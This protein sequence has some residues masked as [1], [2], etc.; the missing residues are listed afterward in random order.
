MPR[1][2]V[3]ITG[4]G[5][6]APN[7]C[8]KEAFWQACL[9]GRSGVRPITR[10]AA[11][12]FS[13]RIAGQIPDFSP[14]AFGLTPIEC[15]FLD[16]GTQ[17]AVAAANLALDD[18]G[19]RGAE[20]EHVPRESIGVYIGTAM[21]SVQ[22]GERLWG[23][24]TGD[25]AHAPRI[26][27]EGIDPSAFILSCMPSAVI[28]SHH[29]LRGPC[30]TI[31][32]GCS[33]GADAIGQAFWQIQEGTAER[34]LAGGSDSPLSPGGL[35]VFSAMHA[36]STHNDEPERASRP[37]EARRD[38]FVLSEG[39]AV[40]LLEERALALARG[41]Y[42]Y[43]EIRTYVTNNNAYHMAT[44]PKDG[45]PLQALLQQ[46]LE[47]SHLSP[48]QLGYIN[49]HGSS[50]VSNDLAETIA[51][52]TFFGARAYQ[53]PISSTKS[54]IGHTQGAASAIE[55]LVTV[56]ALDRQLL[57]P[58]IN[59]EVPDPCCDLDYVPNVARAADA[60]QPLRFALS[61]SSGFGGINTAL[62]LA[63]N[64]A[65][66]E[67]S[68]ASP[69]GQTANPAARL[70][71]R[72]VITGVGVVAPNGIGKAAFWT[73]VCAGRS[74]MGP[75]V[76]HYDMERPLQCVGEIKNFRAEDYIDRKLVKRTDRMSHFALIAA[77]EALLD[78][79]L[80]LERENSLRI[81][82]VIANTLAGVE[83]V[84][85]QMKRLYQLGPNFMSA[86]TALAWL[87][88]AN[89]GRVSVHYGLK[90]YCKVPINDT[91]GGLDAL[92]QGYQAIRRDAAD[93]LIAGG[94]EAPLSP[95]VLCML[96]AT[97]AF[98]RKGDPPCY[99]PFDLRADGL[100]IAEGAGICILEEY[101]HAIRRGAHIYAEIV[102]YAQTCAPGDLTPYSIPDSAAY[103]RA[104]ELALA[105]A[106]MP[107]N[108]IACVFPDGRAIPAWD[109]IET[110]ALSEFFGS[111]FDSL[112][113][114]VPRTQF[115]HTLS[116]AGAIDT[117]CALLTLKEH[118]VPPTINCET[119]NPHHYPPG[120]VRERNAAL[121]F[122][123]QGG[124]VCARGLG[125]SHAV[126][127]LKSMW[128]STRQDLPS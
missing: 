64:D 105:Q 42:V 23:K 65:L 86:H 95:F 126:L 93:I 107:T 80:E 32:T 11:G 116:A 21:A 120:L 29:G 91:C 72:V 48:E 75:P 38:G 28:A 3:V 18:A 41:A 110:A 63:R 4:L 117:I 35:T 54:L 37:Y 122:S 24:A 34:M 82:A 40:L 109:A 98:H 50:T 59:L 102:G 124:L 60:N 123:S 127:A 12:N 43:A 8:G 56:L 76:R 9:Q 55:A 47:S 33:A 119:P 79:G 104:L 5:V 106:E 45:A 101:E 27:P 94:T 87:H 121:R 90:G 17:L 6:L 53:I 113:C 71:R 83:Y 89:V 61:H 70:R 20:L 97:P 46:A 14:A 36:L 99:R 85:E 22:E 66:D 111:Q 88:V 31:G 58:T 84:T 19:L 103:I 128:P 15:R 115:G 7:G 114:T 100:L 77:R 25:G 96:D 92:G 125:G 74:V 13:T 26:P 112:P 78:A 1:R 81:G 68:A 57:P 108:E 67:A 62:V 118:L 30:L 69:Q 2:R 16:R 51:Y 52:K 49:S 73:A 39:S 44:L 10:F